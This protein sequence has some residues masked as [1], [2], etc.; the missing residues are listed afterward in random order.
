MVRKSSSVLTSLLLGARREA[1]AF[2][3]QQKLVKSKKR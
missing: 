1:A 3:A 2:L